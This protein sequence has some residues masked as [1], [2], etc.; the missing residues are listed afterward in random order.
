MTETNNENDLQ[1]ELQNK[2]EVD[3]IELNNSID[4]LKKFVKESHISGQN[5]LDITLVDVNDRDRFYTCLSVV[6]TAIASEMITEENFKA[7]LNL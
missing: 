2:T 5:H 6:K 3:K 4:Y 7:L 1:N